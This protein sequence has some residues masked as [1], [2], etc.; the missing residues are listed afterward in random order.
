MKKSLRSLILVLTLISLFALF[1]V[2]ASAETGNSLRYGRQTLSQRKNSEACLYVYDKLA[3]E[4][5]SY[6]QHRFKLDGNAK[7]MT[8]DDIKDVFNIFK[9]DYP[10]YFWLTGGYKY[11]YDEHTNEILELEPVYSLLKNQIIAMKSD[12]DAKVTELTKDLSNKSQYEQSLIL[13]DRLAQTVDYEATEYDQTAYGALVEGKAVCAGYA[14]AYQLLLHKVGIPGWYVRGSSKSVDTGETVNHG[15]NLVSIDGKWYYTDVTWDDQN[16]TIFHAYLNLP[17]EVMEEDHTVVDFK[18]Y[19]PTS[20]STDASYFYKN[21]LVIDSF[22]PDTFAGLLK[23]NDFIVSFYVSGDMN[24]FKNAIGN[25]DNIYQAIKSTQI[26]FKS[27]SYTYNIVGR[28]IKFEINLK[29]SNYEHRHLMGTAHANEPTCQESG[30]IR[31][32]H[33]AF[34]K[35]YYNALQDGTEITDR[36]SVILPRTEHTPSTNYSFDE[37]EHW[38]TCTVCNKVIIDSV[39]IHIDTDGDSKC[40]VCQSPFLVKPESETVGQ[41]DNKKLE[42]DD[43]DKTNTDGGIES[44]D[45][46]VKVYIIFGVASIIL[47]TVSSLISKLFK[48]R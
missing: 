10:E 16:D 7:G 31:Y 12:L 27:Y 41:T 23:K 6:Q 22:S 36:S 17:F 9:N 46:T 33:C 3:V 35:R 8:R 13:H 2:N 14:R 26:T 44:D 11:S 5:A 42:P 20:N 21:N 34:C 38:K 32:F 25:K 28:E 30:N 29:G 43:Q 19:L 47:Y 45:E 18:E 48:K 39:G 1:N 4:C 24:A 15:W 37:Q 40:D